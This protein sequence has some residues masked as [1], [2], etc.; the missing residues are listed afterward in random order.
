MLFFFLDLSCNFEENLCEWYQD[1]TD[2]FDWTV[3]NGTDH[4]VGNGEQTLI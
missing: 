3:Q 4:T 2:N 1:N